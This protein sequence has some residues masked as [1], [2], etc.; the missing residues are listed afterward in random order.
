MFDVPLRVLKTHSYF[1]VD[2]IEILVGK[3]GFCFVMDSTCVTMMT[4][5][6]KKMDYSRATAA[7]TCIMTSLGGQILQLPYSLSLSNLKQWLLQKVLQRFEVIKK[8]T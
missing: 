5:F 8:M 6:L 1:L 3:H 2:S 4:F 7:G